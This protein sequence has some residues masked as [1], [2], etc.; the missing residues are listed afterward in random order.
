MRPSP[1]TGPE[2]LHE[3]K[4]DGFR[5]QLHKDG[6]DVRLFS[7]NGKDFTDRFPSIAAAV[8]QIPAT[9]VAID[10]EIVVCDGIDRPDFYAL[11]RRVPDGLCVWAF[12]L[13]HLNGEDL[14]G[15]AL[16]ERKAL[17]SDLLAGDVIRYAAHFDDGEKLLEAAADMRLEGIVEAAN[18][19]V[20]C[21]QSVRVVEGEDGGVASGEQR[22]LGAVSK[23]RRLDHASGGGATAA[24][25]SS[26]ELWGRSK[27][28][29]H[30]DAS[31]VHAQAP[32]TAGW[33]GSHR[34]D[35]RHLADIRY[36]D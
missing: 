20:R 33:L 24:G 34:S 17:L 19:G 25:S 15:R 3:I 21:R 12:D 32:Q 11:L 10:G 30:G 1:P 31:P 2:W 13:L 18:G 5:I 23:G 29:R 14:R 35:R 6:R 4:F 9:A 26:F 27:D 8:A 7:R 16:V 36:E 22:S 28:A